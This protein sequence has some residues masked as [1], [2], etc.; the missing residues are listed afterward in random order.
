MI[1]SNAH[2]WAAA[3][4]SGSSLGF[5]CRANVCDIN[6]G[7]MIVAS[8]HTLTGCAS[9]L[10]L[11]QLIASSGRAPLSLPS[12]SCDMCVTVC[13]NTL[14]QLGHRETGGPAALVCGT[15]STAPHVRCNAHKALCHVQVVLGQRDRSTE[16]VA[17]LP[18]ALPV[19][20]TS[21]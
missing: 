16:P 10:I 12:N 13:V 8:A 3:S 5:Q 15:A 20:L 1:D 6:S 2:F 21:P 14:P 11:P 4:A 9:I 7:K 19:P 18:L 17:H